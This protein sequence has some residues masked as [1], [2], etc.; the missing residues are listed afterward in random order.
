[1]TNA[2]AAEIAER[3]NREAAQAVLNGDEAEEDVFHY[4]ATETWPGGGTIT[5][6]DFDGLILG[7]LR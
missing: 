7:E 6:T 1:M 2:E 5:V 4:W 3:L